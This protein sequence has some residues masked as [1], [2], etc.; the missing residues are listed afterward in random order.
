[1]QGSDVETFFNELIDDT[2]DTVATYNA[3]QVAQEKLEMDRDWVK[4]R[5]LDTSI[6]L[7]PSD[8]YQT[9]KTLPT[10]FLKARKV[11]VGAV[12]GEELEEISFENQLVYK[13]IPGYYFID[14]ALGLIYFTG[15]RDQSYTVYLFFKKTMG[16]IASSTTFPWPGSTPLLLAIKMAKLHKSGVDGD[17]INFQM[18]PG[19]REQEKELENS[20]IQWDTGLQLKTMNNRSK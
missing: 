1:M 9:G 2:W 12:D 13:D 6:T 10:G 4:L 11:F 3:M 7:S 20:M 16:V 14:H 5:A 15:T 8:T 17:T 18:T 19:I